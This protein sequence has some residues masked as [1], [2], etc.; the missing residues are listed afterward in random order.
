[1]GNTRP[2]SPHHKS[3]ISILMT[4]QCID[5]NAMCFPSMQGSLQCAKIWLIHHFHHPSLIKEYC[6]V[7][8]V[9]L[10]W[11]ASPVISLGPHGLGLATRPRMSRAG[12]RLR[13]LESCIV[14]RPCPCEI[15]NTGLLVKYP[16]PS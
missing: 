16:G 13:R 11:D 12:S 6:N 1:M 4:M 10:M 3:I 15:L 2:S 8:E 9:F 7:T 5:Y 14:S